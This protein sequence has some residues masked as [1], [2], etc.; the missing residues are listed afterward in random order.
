MKED[1]ENDLDYTSSLASLRK[2]FWEYAL[3]KLRDE[4]NMFLKRNPT[5]VTTLAHQWV[6][7]EHEFM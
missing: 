1:S 3:P 5:L 2:S 7:L 4:T 6:I